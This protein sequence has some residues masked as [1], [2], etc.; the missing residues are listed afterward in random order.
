M[1]VRPATMEDALDVLEWRN[2]PTTRA[3]SRTTDVVERE[4][5]LAWFERTIGSDR[6]SLLIG[7]HEGHKVGMVRIDADG[8]VSINLNPAS[9]GKG[10]A[11][12]FLTAALDTAEGPFIAE[13]KPE[14]TAS[15]RLFEGAGFYAV[16]SGHE[17]LR[18][19]RD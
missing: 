9:R 7:E 11:R 8:E 16:E 6:T 1:K 5:H 15:I 3:M 10:L 18:Y 4:G 2:D 13:I 19:R 14:N 12:P 17:L